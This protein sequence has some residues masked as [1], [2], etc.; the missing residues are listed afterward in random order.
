MTPKD[1]NPQLQIEKLPVPPYGTNTYILLCRETG[2]SAVIDAPGKPETV[3]ALLQGSEP[4]FI[5]M[6]HNH[7]DHTGALVRLRQEL[8]VPVVAHQADTSGLPLTPDLILEDEKI[9]TLGRL[10]LQILHT[11]GHTPGSICLLHED[12]LF[13]GDTL[14]PGGPGRTNSPADFKQ[15]IRSLQEKI[16]SLRR[17]CRVYPGH[18]EAT[19]LDTERKDFNDFLS[20]GLPEGLCGNVVW[21]K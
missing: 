16:F 2:Q 18:G 20:R 13:S 6:T 5:F 7:F 11:P 1:S 19:W 15:I 9:L 14:F 17:N 12:V 21:H 3:L 10:P 8:Q 4:R